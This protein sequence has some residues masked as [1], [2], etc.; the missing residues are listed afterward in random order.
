MKKTQRRK[1][2]ILINS[3]RGST[4]VE[5]IVCFA[6]LSIF[7]ACAATMISNI[8]MIYYNVKGEIYA[9]E[10]SDIV[11]GKIES[12]IDGALF[13]KPEEY[14]EDPSI[15]TDNKSITLYDKTYTQVKLFNDGN[16]G[17]NVQYQGFEHSV[18]GTPIEDESREKTNWYFD[19]TV[20]NDFRIVDLSFYQ[21]GT[22]I[23]S[24]SENDKKNYGLT[25]LDMTDY[26]DNIIL[27]LM[28][29]DSGRYGEYYFYRF[30]KMYNMPESTPTPTPPGG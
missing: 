22:A 28:K 16:K 26:G 29:M 4:L 8:T 14:G 19:K 13:F 25:D 10:V 17:L 18:N 11:L 9:R 21:G 6:L 23:T 20:Y 1:A 24:F 2:Y 15:E 30:V 12:E 5:M 27:V 3:N 7:M